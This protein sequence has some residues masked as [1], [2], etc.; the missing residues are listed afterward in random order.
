MKKALSKRSALKL[1]PAI[2]CVCLALIMGVG[3]N[4]DLGG[5]NAAAAGYNGAT[6]TSD[7][8]SMQEAV[9]AEL[10]V[11]KKIAG[12]GYVLLKNKG[13]A[14][15]VAKG[16]KIS[17]FGKNSV[18][19]IMTGTG[20]SGGAA[21]G[22]TD[23]IGGL[24]K[25]GFAVNETLVEFYNDDKLSGTGRSTNGMNDLPSSYWNTGE[26]AQA[27]YTDKVKK[28]YDEYGDAAILVFS[29]SGGEGADLAMSSFAKTAGQTDVDTGSSPTRA[30]IDNEIAGEGNWSPVG[31]H[32]RETNPFEHYLELDD[33][34]KALIE[35]VE[36]SG[37]FGKVIVLLNSMNA[38]EAGI[39]EDDDKVDSVIWAPGS[40]V[41]G[42]ES[43]G[44]II[45]GEINP[46][47]KLTDT[48]ARD[49]T[50]SP[51]WQ[52]ESNNRIG[53]GSG[54]DA[55]S[56]NQYTTEDGALFA[57]DNTGF[58]YFGSD[59]EE[60][61]Y[62]GY[63][64]YETA[65]AEKFIDYDK[66]VVYPFGY[67]LSYTSFEWT[68]GTPSVTANGSFTKDTQFTFPVTVKNTGGVAGKDVVQLY[69]EA[70]YTPGKIE[71]SKVALGDFVKTKLLGPDEEQTVSVTVSA[72]DMASFDVYDLNKNGKHVWELDSGKYTMYVGGDAHCWAAADALKVEYDLASGLLWETDPMS[73]ED[74]SVW[75][76][77]MNAEMKGKTLSRADFAGTFPQSP[78]WFETTADMLD[79]F[80]SAQYR[81]IF[82]KNY[83]A[84]DWAGGKTLSPAKGKTVPGDFD[85]APKYLKASAAELVK[86]DEWLDKMT[87]PL[88]DG[89][90][91]LDPVI[92]PEW[93]ATAGAD[94]WYYVAPG[95]AADDVPEGAKV[96]TYKFRDAAEAYSDKKLM[97]K[98]D[99]TI[100][101]LAPIQLADLVGKDYG[102]P[103]WDE[104]TAQFTVDQAY[105][106]INGKYSQFEYSGIAAAFGIPTGGHSDG[107][108]GI[109][110]PWVGE[111]YASM[112]DFTGAV[113]FAPET[114]VAATWNK[115]LAGEMGKAI[116][117]Y[118]LWLHCSGWYAPGAN[119]HRSPFAGRN[120]EYYSEDAT[121]TGGML[122][123]VVTEA[124]KKGLVCFI[125]HIALN[126][127]E[128]YRECN[129]MSV[130]TN[131][132]A[133]R[134]IYLRG[135]EKAVKAV[136]AI[137]TT[138]GTVTPAG[139]MSSFNSIGFNWAG[140]TWEFINGLMRSEWGFVGEVVTDA[141][142][143]GNGKMSANMM[144]RAGNDLGLDGKASTTT[145]IAVC[146]NSEE[147]NTPTQLQG[148]YDCVKRQLY[149]LLN[150]SA[151]MNGYG[152][153]FVENYV[154]DNDKNDV[155]YK[156]SGYDV[157]G[158]SA[159][160]AKSYLYR[161]GDTGLNISVADKDL[162][163][164]E[165]RL[166]LGKLPGTL[167]LD[168]ATGAITGDIPLDTP[169]G[170]YA[171]SVATTVGTND[172][173]KW[174][175]RKP[176]NYFKIV[177]TDAVSF[178]GEKAVNVAPDQWFSIDVT[179]SAKNG[180]NITYT[181]DGSKLPEGVFLSPEGRL[182]GS[183]TAAGTYTV[184]VTATA[185]EGGYLPV[186][187][188][189]T[190]NAGA[191]SYEKSELGVAYAGISYSASVAN[192]MLTNVPAGTPVQV[193]Y[194]LK[195]GGW[196][197]SGSTLPDGLTLG[198]NGVIYGTAT[199]AV[200]NHTFTVV[201]DAGIYGKAEATFTITVKPLE[202]IKGDKGDQG[203]KG[204]KG[205]PGET[206]PKG[207]KGD[208]G[209]AA[210]GCGGNVAGTA[211]C[212][213]SA[214]AGLA[215]VFFALKRKNK[216]E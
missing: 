42:F 81:Y 103:A 206:G 148:L 167:T 82:G 178:Q 91:H 158:A 173:D 174:V 186:T 130:W 93:D 1:I 182:Y 105:A 212:V 30:N 37:K 202:D 2:V 128:T 5:A 75:F 119:M 204:D 198:A 216:A 40:G 27:D 193:T 156:S 70:P 16:A 141:F 181:T 134:E 58:G 35:A 124:S 177:V 72:F 209:E 95:T 53:N 109:T 145:S 26:T 6:F 98:T 194:S 108:Q 78:Y 146:T 17:V 197:S 69:Y 102:D 107:P 96:G 140:G 154:D 19:P 25:A 20:S 67:G 22:S 63:K 92:D 155:P 122:T 112:A 32:G 48:F 205:D 172:A 116:G 175:I 160:K 214:L 9:D 151:M 56:G 49:F 50:K 127:Q 207:D 13:N 24:K 97:K 7:Y 65:A 149:C 23:I 28:S 189:I 51:V 201:A 176:I 126:D 100:E 208:A 150:S 157:G 187:T 14:L 52:N 73:G 47:G 162:S 152:A 180:S 136:N 132:Q 121:L 129:N 86:N 138:A 84:D 85:V 185:E 188:A 11:N 163:G 165:Y 120:F 183:V 144:I 94:K 169:S 12:E 34:E 166:Y 153:D 210:G 203:E 88:A 99:G 36:S 66:E 168:P 38:F 61:I 64:Y 195:A 74:V 80:W 142:Q 164:I 62:V 41:N 211:V 68:L 71:K 117:D 133:M 118:A 115:E 131:E 76:D 46:S 101:G 106:A 200:E 43:L 39:L 45:S 33:N 191:L 89:K 15:P 159:A 125:K 87:L 213:G 143:S 196:G 3:I 90:T 31:G 161:Q 170:T 79:P 59:Y 21:A 215:I 135:F 44:K 114:L 147:A 57:G 139:M 184:N 111:K 60:G 10:E 137:E 104:F 190:I 171:F 18:D 123:A 199:A 113:G 54:V 192:A 110:R 77:D 4:A 179:S 55:G 8:N 83:D 29:R